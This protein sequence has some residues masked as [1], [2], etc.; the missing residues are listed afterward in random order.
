MDPIDTVNYSRLIQQ[1]TSKHDTE[2]R[3]DKK[4]M[5]AETYVSFPEFGEIERTKK[6][7]STM[8]KPEVI[9]VEATPCFC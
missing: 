3:L 5:F 4:S 8:M 9:I 2:R 6:T 7:V 1:L